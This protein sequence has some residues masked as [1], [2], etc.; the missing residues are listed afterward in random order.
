MTRS[1]LR[2]EERR[3]R[4][5]DLLAWAGALLLGAVVAW[6]VFSIQALAQ[7][8]ATANEA[9]DALARQV[10]QLGEKPV[11]GPP[12]S[13]GEPGQSVTGPRGPKGD[14]GEPGS[15]GPT[16]PSGEDGSDGADATGKPGPAGETGK[17]G[18]AGTDG[19]PG[20]AGPQGE[21]GPAGAEGP[22][23]PQGE[24]GDTGAR[25]E[26]G[27]PPSGWTYTDPKGVTYECTPDGD[28]STHY[29]CRSNQSAP[30]PSNPGNGPLNLGLDPQRRQYP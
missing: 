14:K 2:A 15:P 1:R 17:P 19:Q 24:K 22:Q 8:L 12:G 23:G 5:G 10:Q 3:W 4:R 18:D 20:P 25:G 30:E 11:A 16:G 9:R 6:V 29:T 28:G 21:P 26:Q 13:R 27:P 7:E